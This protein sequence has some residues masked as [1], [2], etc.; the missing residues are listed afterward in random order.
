MLSD[1]ELVEEIG[2]SQTAVVHKA[3]KDQRLYAIKIFRLLASVEDEPESLPGPAELGRDFRLPF[4]RAAKDQKKAAQEGE[5]R[6]APIHEAGYTE[7][8][9][10]AWYA[11]DFY[12]RGSLK[13]LVRPDTKLRAADLRAVVNSVARALLDLKCLTGRSHGNLK[14][15]NILRGGRSGDRWPRT[16]LFLTDLLDGT[17]AEADAFE[18]ADL[19]ALAL[20]IYQLVTLR[21][22]DDLD[23][24]GK[25]DETS[26]G[27]D[28]LGKQGPF[29]RHIFNR[30]RDDRLSLEAVE[31][32]E[33]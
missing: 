19:R 12:Q 33:A 8:G 27:W 7:D 14:P 21:E 6:C 30:L 24:I 4:L 20:L 29:W 16:P 17:E 9:Q 11:T 15:S 3:R 13:R 28:R 5:R 31:S 1:Y 10:G 25:Q 32:G 18:R 2:R 22:A 23:N 26:E